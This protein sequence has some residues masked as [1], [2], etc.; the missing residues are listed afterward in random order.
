MIIF[1]FNVVSEVT[2]QFKPPSQPGQWDQPEQENQQPTRPF[3]KQLQPAETNQPQ[4]SQ[5]QQPEYPP[6]PETYYAPTQYVPPSPSPPAQ[7][8]PKKR[9]S[10]SEKTALWIIVSLVAICVVIVGIVFAAA[11][12]SSNNAP[13]LSTADQQ[14]TA[15]DIATAEAIQTVNANQNTSSS[16]PI[17]TAVPTTPTPTFATFSDGTY[18]VGTDIQPG[19]YRTQTGSPGCYYARLKGFG[20]TNDD[21]LANNLTDYP[22]IVTILPSDKGF[23]SQNC[24]TWTK[25]L[26]QITTS[27]TTFGDGMYIVGT[28]IQP[29]TYRNTTSSGCYYARL[30]G[31]SNTDSDIIANNLT[32]ASA[33]VTISASDKGFESTRCGTWTKL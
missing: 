33:I 28:D 23:E 21:I 14:A 17:A 22:A 15:A 12:G 1:R 27:K 9:L 3:M 16:Q 32:D 13:S 18:Q 19:T 10:R 30:S 20:G 24:G 6:K 29:G 11:G 5:G 25:D 31:F 4:P 7:Q 8:P 2:M 26:S